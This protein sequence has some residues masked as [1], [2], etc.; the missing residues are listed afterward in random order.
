MAD[1]RIEVR[2]VSCRFGE[3]QAL[4]GVS[5][6]IGSGQMVGLIG[7]NGAGKSTLFKVML[8][9]I[10]PTSGDVLLDGAPVSGERFRQARRRI[11]YLPETFAT[12][13]NLT[14]GEVLRL[15]A[16]LKGVP[17]KECIG[18]LERVGLARAAGRRVGGYS[19]GMRQR[20][21]FAQVLLG[22]PDLVFLDEPT[23]GLDPEGIHDFY[24]VLREVQAG[25]T[26][27]VITSHILADIQDRVDQLVILRA[28]RVAARGTL[29]EL[30]ASTSQHARIEVRVRE[31][32]AM[33]IEASLAGEHAIEVLADRVRIAC[34][35]HQKMALIARVAALGD[36]V[37]DLSVQ[38]ASLE[39][40]FL[41]FGGKHGTH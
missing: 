40:L 7:H 6:A 20:L 13:D 41:G 21:G 1:Y 10:Q 2:N 37:L 26:T 31:G 29:A 22:E 4:D 14:G 23:N 8:G 38:E 34:A 17:R 28:G 15:F 3:V 30:R 36:A 35:P 39:Q 12:Y 5:L 25:G 11:G 27:V 9:L 24:Q 19:K 32:D 16:D 33:R 18:V